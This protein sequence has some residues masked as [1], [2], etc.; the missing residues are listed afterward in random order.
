MLC[1]FQV[2]SQVFKMMKTFNHANGSRAL[3]Q[4]WGLSE[5]RALCSHW[6]HTLEAS[7]HFQC[8]VWVEGQLTLASGTFIMDKCNPLSE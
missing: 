1:Y 4:A 8:G 3:K 2:Y 5:Y 6:S 7:L